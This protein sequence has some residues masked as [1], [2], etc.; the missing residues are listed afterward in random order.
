MRE[1]IIEYIKSW[2][3]K[4]YPDDIPD[5]IPIELEKTNLVPSYKMIAKAILSNDISL[6]SLGYTPKKSKWYSILKKIEVENNGKKI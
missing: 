1:K 5:E 6:K 4:G 2:K 3:N